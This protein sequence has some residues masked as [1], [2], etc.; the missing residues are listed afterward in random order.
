[1]PVRR[2]FLSTITSSIK[3]TRPP[4]AVETS[5]W[6][7]AMPMTIA[8]LI[9]TRTSVLPDGSAISA[10]RPC[11]CFSPFGEKSDSMLKS[12]A[13][14]S[15]IRGMSHGCAGRIIMSTLFYPRSLFSQVSTKPQRTTNDNFIFGRLFFVS[16]WRHV[17]PAVTITRS[18]GHD[19]S[20]CRCARRL[21]IRCSSRAGQRT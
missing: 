18:H 5:V 2:C 20:S 11:T 13:S 4:S 7:V 19:I 8:L 14:S 16:S 9:A 1:M 3:P 21:H 17:R 6:T 12:S 15:H 10:P